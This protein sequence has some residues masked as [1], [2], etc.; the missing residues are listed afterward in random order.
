[1]IDKKFE[2]NDQINRQRGIITNRSQRAGERA[3][4]GASTASERRLTAFFKAFYNCDTASSL[5]VGPQNLTLGLGGKFGIIQIVNSA[6]LLK[7]KIIFIIY[8]KTM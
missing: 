6:T 5:L 7:S 4:E 1:M 2:P 8:L 3:R